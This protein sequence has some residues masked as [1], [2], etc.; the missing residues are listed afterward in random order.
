VAL[1]RDERVLIFAMELL[2][3]GLGENTQAVL[4]NTQRTET[5][6]REQAALAQQF[7][8]QTPA[9]GAS[10]GDSGMGGPPMPAATPPRGAP[11]AGT[12]APVERS[13][14][15]GPTA[16]AAA[17]PARSP[18]GGPGR[19]AAGGRGG[20]LGGILGLIGPVVTKFAAILGPAALLAQMM[21]AQ[22]SG[23]GV[24]TSS[25]KVLATS[26]A[27]VLLP[28]TVLLSTALLAISEIITEELAPV[29]QIGFQQMMELLPVLTLLI[30]IFNDA[31]TM[32]S[33]FVTA[34][35]DAL[36]AFVRWTT[37]LN[38][39]TSEAEDALRAGELFG[40]P[41]VSSRS[42]KDRVDSGLNDTLRS[43]QMSIGPKAQSSG[44][45]EV[46]KQVQMAALQQDPIEARML[47]IQQDMLARLNNIANNTSR[48]SRPGPYNPVTNPTGAGDYSGSGTASVGGDYGG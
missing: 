48:G 10:R 32:V 12:G 39:L 2:R 14:G 16:G 36:I 18:G 37:A 4:A 28:A 25:V 40:I 45:A 22:I 7:T 41:L 34:I 9:A 21:Q 24:L 46:G 26:L 6:F 20:A 15:G 13:P 47:K 11:A 38:P 3:V 42:G 23:F 44:L 5:M 35:S 1:S 33:D 27:P 8:G 31:A 17:P 43:L 29:M 19:G 30:D